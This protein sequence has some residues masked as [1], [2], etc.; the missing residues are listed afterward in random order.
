MRET[1]MSQVSPGPLPGASVVVS[2]THAGPAGKELMLNWVQKPGHCREPRG[3]V[4]SGLDSETGALELTSHSQSL[5]CE[6][7]WPC[8]ESGVQSMGENEE[9]HQSSPAKSA[10]FR[11]CL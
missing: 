5:E 8:L 1:K 11:P 9:S 4:D 7:G 6:H 3:Q 10:I 2:T